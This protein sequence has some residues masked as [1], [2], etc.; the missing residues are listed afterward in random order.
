MPE[1]EIFR[2][3]NFVVD[4]QGVGSGY[5]SEVSGL[6]VSVETIEYREGGG[7][8]AVRKLPGRVSYA[9]ITLKW[10]MSE[11]R[12]LWDWLMATTEGNFERRD[13]SVILLKPDGQ[14]EDTRWNLYNTY[15]SDWRGARLEA[16]GNQVAIETLTLVIERLER[17]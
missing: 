2:A 6:G 8:P 7:A 10:G 12:E 1:S 15:P 3:Y 17:A 4:I 9:D 14:Q 13:V 16:M 5:F 11:S